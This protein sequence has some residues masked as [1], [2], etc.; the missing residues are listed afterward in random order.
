V[1][2][3]FADCGPDLDRDEI[4]GKTDPLRGLIDH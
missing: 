3:I 2:V 4:D 1:D